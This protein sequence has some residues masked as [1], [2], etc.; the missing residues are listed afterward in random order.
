[1]SSKRVIDY[2]A[3]MNKP[4]V[5]VA[6]LSCVVSV[7]VGCGGGGSGTSGASSAAASATPAASVKPGTSGAATASAAPSAAPSAAAAGAYKGLKDGH[8]A[9]AF[10]KDPKD[11]G[12]CGVLSA[13][14]AEKAKLNDEKI[15]DIA[16]LLKG[17]VTS[18]CPTQNIVGACSA[19]GVVV[20]YYGPKYTKETAKKDC[21]GGWTE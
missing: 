17:E 9:I 11:E 20:Q 2:K 13:T 14:A 18:T 16:K 3:L 21:K 5:A 19:F 4:A 7:L 12:Q 15:K 6:F 1:M 10:I 8:T